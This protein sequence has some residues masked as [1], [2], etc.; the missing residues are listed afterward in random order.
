MRLV[1][2][3]NTVEGGEG[4]VTLREERTGREAGGEEMVDNGEDKER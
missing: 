3:P 2:D 1:Q 4:E